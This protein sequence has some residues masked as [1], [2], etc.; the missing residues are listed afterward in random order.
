MSKKI[1]EVP[2][3]QR[4]NGNEKLPISDG[5]GLAKA[6]SVE[7][8]TAM[9]VSPLFASQRMKTTLQRLL[10]CKL[11]A[12]VN[13]SPWGRN[14][15]GLMPC[16]MAVIETEGGGNGLALKVSYIDFDGY[17]RHD[18]YLL[19]K[20]DGDYIK[21]TDRTLI[22]S[23]GEVS[24]SERVIQDMI[25]KTPISN[26]TDEP[27]ISDGTPT[28]E[29]T[30]LDF[31]SP[32]SNGYA[33]DGSGNYLYIASNDATYPWAYSADTGGLRSGN[34]GINSSSSSV[35]IKCFPNATNR[36]TFRQLSEPFYDYCII[37]GNA[38]NIIKTLISDSNSVSTPWQGN[39]L[40]FEFAVGSDPII[41]F[42]FR[43]DV[44]QSN[45][46]DSF[47]LKSVA[48]V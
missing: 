15:I 27:P 32:S 4:C 1:Y 30:F 8:I 38:G 22:Y 5:S 29:V 10:S 3:K 26:W 39:E 34:R 42:A 17:S 11:Y 19:I 44:S 2:L 13:L 36:I 45:L 43:K 14:Y 12:T 48:K 25:T 16:D 47:T 23:N 41:E 7:T 46:D 21:G 40:T 31:T 33:K 37:K 28:E 35:K 9:D 24:D 6:T 20:Q 18:C